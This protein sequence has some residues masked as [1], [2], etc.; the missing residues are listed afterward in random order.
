MKSASNL[1][2]R[3][4][5][6]PFSLSDLAR[7][8]GIQTNE[9]YDM[10]KDHEQRSDNQNFFL[11]FA[12]NNKQSPAMCEEGSLGFWVLGLPDS[13]SSRSR[14]TAVQVDS[15]PP[16]FPNRA[17]PL[18]KKHPKQAVYTTHVDKALPEENIDFGETF[19]FFSA[20]WTLC[21]LRRSPP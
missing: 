19:P 17:D 14:M 6:M 15:V 12:I 1:L 9:K 16:A 2:L 13:H 4:R 10:T 5:V 3:T 20:F 21:F 18:K 7:S 8:Q 11:S